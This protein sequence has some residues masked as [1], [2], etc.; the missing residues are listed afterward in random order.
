MTEYWETKDGAPDY[1]IPFQIFAGIL[2]GLSSFDYVIY[3]I[4]MFY[5]FYHCYIQTSQRSKHIWI[6]IVIIIFIGLRLFYIPLVINNLPQMYPETNWLSGSVF[7]VSIWT[8]GGI[9]LFLLILP[10]AVIMWKE[11]TRALGFHKSKGEIHVDEAPYVMVVM[12]VYNEVNKRDKK[13]RKEKKT[14]YL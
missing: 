13:K 4:A 6:I 11:I 14:F 8:T 3:I 1:P 7:I 9:Y 2:I 12:P 10:M 5:C